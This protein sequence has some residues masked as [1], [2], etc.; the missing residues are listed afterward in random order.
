MRDLLR[1]T[2]TMRMKRL[3][4]S[5]AQTAGM[6]S[7]YRR[8]YQAL[9]FIISRARP[10]FS[11]APSFNAASN[12]RC[13]NCPRPNSGF[14]EGHWGRSR[15]HQRPWPWWPSINLA[16]VL[17]SKAILSFQLTAPLR[18]LF[19][20]RLE[21]RNEDEVHCLSAHCWIDCNK[22]SEPPF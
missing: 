8:I 2:T 18:D 16:L 5:R 11:R 20:L 4:P 21:L 7:S 19:F 22:N 6:E 3:W 10:L 9:N 15:V 13:R 17:H 1:D 12:I 14:W